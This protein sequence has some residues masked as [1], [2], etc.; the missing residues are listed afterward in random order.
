MRFWELVSDYTG[1]QKKSLIVS[2]QG[3]SYNL[4]IAELE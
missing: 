3:D 4:G 2:I 1:Q